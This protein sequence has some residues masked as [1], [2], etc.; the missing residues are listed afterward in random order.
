ME[1]SSV[2]KKSPIELLMTQLYKKGFLKEID[3]NEP[4]NLMNKAKEMEKERIIELIQFIVSEKELVDYS[5]V[6]KET[7]NYY[8]DKFNQG[9]G[10]Q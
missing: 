4:I 9:G 8:Y 5:S 10:E 6:S 1:Q 3:G 7:A 2:E